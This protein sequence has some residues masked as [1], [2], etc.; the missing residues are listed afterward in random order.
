MKARKGK[1]ESQPA[2]RWKNCPGGICAPQGFLAAAGRAGLKKAGLDVTVIMSD[3]DASA[4][5]C[6]TQNKCVAAPVELSQRHLKKSG[7]RA[8]AVLVNSGCANAATGAPGVDSAHST[9][10]ALARFLDVPESS[11]LVC[12][13][14]VIGLPLQAERIIAALPACLARLSRAEAKR[15]AQA[16]TTTDTVVKI[17][18]IEFF[19]GADAARIG[20]MAKG[21]GM[22]HPDMATMLAFITTDARIEPKQLRQCL[23][24]CVDRSF[25]CITVD[26]DTST[27][28]TVIVLANGA[29]A[30]DV[31]RGLDYLRFRD[32]LLE[33]CQRLARK[34]AWDGEG[35]THHLEIRVT[36]A[37]SFSQAQSVGRSVGRSNLVK[38]AIY[39][40]DPNWGRVLSA[41][42]ASGER[43]NIKRVRLSV[44]STVVAENGVLKNYP[45]AFF[46]RV[47][48]KK[49]IEFSV[50]LGLGPHAVTCWSC[51]L[52]HE[53]VDINASYRT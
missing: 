2:T 1:T 43:L 29:A 50:D 41:V 10:K 9:V 30:V 47:W 23:Q 24:W 44:D 52:S 36:G 28:D 37:R 48:K 40:H 3:R 17:E 46:L 51:D 21:A 6:F 13:T 49:R 25:N 5:A 26:G 7:G 12:S 18:S 14:G 27:N 19:S 4:A 45:D 22:I 20:G 15:A 33:V 42:G 32:A 34:V 11:I 16:I 38:T 31:R 39:G 53:Y 8:R 35:A